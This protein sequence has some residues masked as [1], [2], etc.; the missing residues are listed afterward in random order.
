MNQPK[1]QTDVPEDGAGSDANPT[2]TTPHGI[3]EG[4]ADH[5]ATALPTSDRQA[6]EVA[7][8]TIQKDAP[9]KA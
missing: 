5:E 1:V 2:G 6:A 8:V 7:P 9:N 4:Q 3:P